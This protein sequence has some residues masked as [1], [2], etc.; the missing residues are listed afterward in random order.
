[1]NPSVPVRPQ[2]GANSNLSPE[3]EATPQQW[4]QKQIALVTTETCSVCVRTKFSFN[5]RT[6]AFVGT[7]ISFLS[8]RHGQDSVSLRGFIFETNKYESTSTQCGRPPNVPALLF[9]FFFS[10]Q[11]NLQRL[12]HVF[13]T[14]CVSFS[15]MLLP[16]WC[17]GYTSPPRLVPCVH[18]KLG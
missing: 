14:S 5:I 1:M 17:M 4:P 6:L 11:E 8:F 12:C 9:L 16:W 15:F 2:R 13:S 3:N 7:F 18:C 10:L